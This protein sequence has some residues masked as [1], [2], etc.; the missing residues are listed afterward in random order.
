MRRILLATVSILATLNALLSPSLACTAVDIVAAD[1][2]V[3]AGRTME[4]AFDMKW[5]LVSQ[6]KGTKLT[7][8]APKALSLPA[9]SVTTKYSVVGVSAGVIPGCWKAKTRPASA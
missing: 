2:S 9:L 6:P 7:L 5:T 3:I 1:K 8:E 4:W